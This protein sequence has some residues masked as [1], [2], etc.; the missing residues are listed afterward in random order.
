MAYKRLLSS[1]RKLSIDAQ[2]LL[3]MVLE[4]LSGSFDID[5]IYEDFDPYMQDLDSLFF[6]LDRGN[7]SLES[8]KIEVEHLYNDLAQLC[9]LGEKNKRN[10]EISLSYGFMLRSI[11]EILPILVS[12]EEETI[13]QA[14]RHVEHE[15]FSFCFPEIGEI[16][17]RAFAIIEAD[18]ENRGFDAIRV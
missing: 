6:K 3:Y 4:E 2:A 5:M 9:E 13:S 12:M 15:G 10:E 7:S 18:Y 11:K 16:A 17:E 1:I 14:L 8:I